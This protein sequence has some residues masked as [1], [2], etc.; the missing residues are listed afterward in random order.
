[1]THPLDPRPFWN[2]GGPLLIAPQPALGLWEGTDAP[3]G[4]RVVTA[5]SRWRDPGAPACDYDRAC[6]VDPGSA[7]A[8]AIGDSWGVVIGTA[9]GQSA[10]WLPAGDAGTFYALGIEAADDTAPAR[11]LA[12]ASTP[13]EWRV[14]RERAAVG[15]EGLLLT[16]AASR[17]ADVRELS[18]VASARDD[19]AVIG[20]GLRYAAPAGEY[21][22]SV[23]DVVTL[24]G[25]YLTFIRFALSGRGH[26]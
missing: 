4:G 14:L 7:G 12:L 11:L 10:Q 16:H 15:P 13:G 23:R 2:D 22:I 6:D 21:A 24:G 25:E 5:A 3:G 1:M 19:G 18:A 17:P 26:R 8:V 9:A 20:D